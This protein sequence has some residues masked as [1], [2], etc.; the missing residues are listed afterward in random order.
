MSGGDAAQA[1]EA[2]DVADH[3]RDP[4]HL[5]QRLDPLDELVPASMSTPASR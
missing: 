3:L 2:A 4:G 5:R 1:G